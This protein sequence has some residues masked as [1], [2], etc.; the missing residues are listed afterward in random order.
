MAPEWVQKEQGGAAQLTYK[1]GK[2]MSVD[3]ESPLA[4]HSEHDFKPHRLPTALVMTFFF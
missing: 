3:G 2:T 4:L 1:E